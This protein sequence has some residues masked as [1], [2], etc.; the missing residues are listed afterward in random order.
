MR[1]RITEKETLEEIQRRKMIKVVEDILMT[2]KEKD[3]DVREKESEVPSVL[4]KN[5]KSL[6]KQADKHGISMS[7]LIKALKSE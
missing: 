5:I 2:K 6:K 7:K 3:S 1:I 4:L